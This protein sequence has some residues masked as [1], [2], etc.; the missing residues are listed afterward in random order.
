LVLVQQQQQP[1]GCWVAA[2]TVGTT[3]CS[4]DSM[5]SQQLQQQ[6]ITRP[7]PQALLQQPQLRPLPVAKLE[8][9]TAA[10]AAVTSCTAWSI[11]LA[12]GS[13]KMKPPQQQQQPPL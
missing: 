5:V 7:W 4:R 2:C 1:Q 12:W 10:L 8:G 9:S 11:W 6:A 13:S 3:T